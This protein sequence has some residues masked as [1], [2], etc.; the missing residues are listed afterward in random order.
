ML[1]SLILECNSPSFGTH[2]V[3]AIRARYLDRRA[4]FTHAIGADHVSYRVRADITSSKSTRIDRK[5]MRRSTSR[6]IIHERR[7]AAE[8]IPQHLCDIVPSR[9]LFLYFRSKDTSGINHATENNSKLLTQD[10]RMEKIIYWMCQP[11]RSYL[12]IIEII[13]NERYEHKY[14]KPRIVN[15][16]T[17]M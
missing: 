4:T 15:I 9:I 12:I 1:R 7:F 17:V 3:V 11:A 16:L 10:A 14:L 13:E 8:I 2:I 6:R 5:Y